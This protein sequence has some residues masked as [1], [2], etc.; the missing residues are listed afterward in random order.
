MS[1]GLPKKLTEAWQTSSTS[2][3]DF[4]RTLSD[5]IQL[6]N[7]HD[8]Y[9]GGH[10][11]RVSDYAGDIAKVMGLGRAQLTLV[12]QTGL[13]HDIG[14]IAIPDKLLQK[15]GAL[16]DEE[17][18]LIR[19]HPIFGAAVLSRIPGTDE[20]IPGVL[21]HHE[22]WDGCGYP[23]GLSGV[24]IPVEARIIFVADA[25]DAMTTRRPYGRVLSLDEAMTEIRVCSGKQFDPLVVDALHE[26][27]R[28]GLLDE[29]RAPESISL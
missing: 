12:K 24:D 9:T 6:V 3:V 14:K 18:H 7:D 25:L 2:R 8:T 23:A 13:V 28:F 17:T 15:V 5:L 22:T 29:H 1:I 19:L 26:A 21:H 11:Y 4:H 20:M 10:S 27:Y 16:N